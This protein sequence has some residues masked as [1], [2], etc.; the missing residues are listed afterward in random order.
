MLLPALVI[1]ADPHIRRPITNRF[2]RK[3]DRWDRPIDQNG[4]IAREKP[5]AGTL[6]AV[7]RW[8]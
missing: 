3:E 1:V 5:S 8:E 2:F 7:D 4:Y 6:A